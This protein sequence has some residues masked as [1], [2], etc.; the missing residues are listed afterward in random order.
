MHDIQMKTLN[1]CIQSTSKALNTFGST[2]QQLE[3]GQPITPHF[4]IG[5]ERTI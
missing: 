3:A 5:F 2:L 4:S 1:I